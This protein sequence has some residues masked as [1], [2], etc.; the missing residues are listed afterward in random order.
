[1]NS[2]GNMS[3]RSGLIPMIEP[4]AMAEILSSVADLGLVVAPGG[5]ILGV[6]TS[7][8]I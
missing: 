3:W 4:N 7:P 8:K 1:M 5:Q 2:F 6:L